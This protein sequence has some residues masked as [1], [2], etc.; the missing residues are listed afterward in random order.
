MT[1]GDTT[2]PRRTEPKLLAVGD[3]E[4]VYDHPERVGRLA[5]LIAEHRTPETIVC[6]VGDNTALGTLAVL[7]EEGRGEAAPF[8]NHIQPDIDTIGN[9]DLDP[10]P[11]WFDA[12]TDRV[13]QRFLCANITGLP[14]S[15]TPGLI[16]ERAG[17]RIAVIGVT[18]P[19]QISGGS[20]S[21]NFADPVA[22][23]NETS[24]SLPSHDYLV[25]CAHWGNDER[26][27]T[28]T[29]AD[30]VLGAHVHHRWVRRING[31]LL[32]SPAGQGREILEIELS[33]SPTA[34]VHDVSE[35]PCDRGIA[36][37]YR[38]RRARFGVD[39]VITTVDEPLARTEVTRFGGESR[40]GNFAADA[41][42]ANANTDIGLFPAG[43]IRT[44]P[45]LED[46]VTTGDII[47]IAP[48]DDSVRTLRLTGDAIWQILANAGHPREGDR[49]WVDF[50][51]SG[52]H[53]TWRA[54][55][56]LDQVRRPDGTFSPESTYTVATTGYVVMSDT[57]ST[58]R[59]KHVASTH[60]SLIDALL[61]HARAGELHPIQCDGRLQKSSQESSRE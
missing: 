24:E 60:D 25:V 18:H 42:R 17:M 13:P 33:S 31:T 50:H 51:L 8:M 55:H 21:L 20:T 32:A 36:A 30:V 40:I 14:R 1:A 58:L 52:L 22:A 57:F 27:A 45:P 28:E 7:S 38:Q 54:D 12:W 5:G 15:L 3:L 2:T 59:E 53:A 35:G 10:G 41:I 47:G 29:D 43:S 34:T 16:L 23:V 39:E 6:G 37:E 4:S 49:G 56:S 19:E 48:F 9:H 11:D 61:D 26:L 46:A 44:G